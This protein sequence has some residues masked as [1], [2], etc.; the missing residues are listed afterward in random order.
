MGLLGL[1]RSQLDRRVLKEGITR[2]FKV[3]LEGPAAVPQEE[4]E[5]LPHITAS[6]TRANKRGNKGRE[7][8]KR[9]VS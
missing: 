1:G 9:V 8:T 2:R 6:T 3:A 5:G 4:P 7:G